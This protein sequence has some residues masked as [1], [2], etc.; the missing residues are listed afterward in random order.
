MQGGGP[1]PRAGWTEERSPPRQPPRVTVESD[2]G[3]QRIGRRSGHRPFLSGSEVAAAQRRA[4]RARGEFVQ[5][6]LAAL[7]RVA[8]AERLGGK[9]Q[10]AQRAQEAPVGLVRP[11]HPAAASLAS[12]AEAVAPAGGGGP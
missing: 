8:L 10:A 9:L 6:R 3:S 1:E 5:D 7:G 11:G 2:E 12:L 4:G